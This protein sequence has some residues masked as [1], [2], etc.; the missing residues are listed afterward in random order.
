MCSS[1]IKNPINRKRKNQIKKDLSY[2]EILMKFSIIQAFYIFSIEVL[3]FSTKIIFKEKPGLSKSLSNHDLDFDKSCELKQGYLGFMDE[4]LKNNEFHIKPIFAILNM[5]YFSIFENDTAT[6]LIKTI[7]LRYIRSPEKPKEW[8]NNLCFKLLVDSNEPTPFLSKNKKK[9]EKK[10]GFLNKFKQKP[11]N[12]STEK[13]GIIEKKPGVIEEKT[14]IKHENEIIPENTDIFCV[15]DANILKSWMNSLMTFHNCLFSEKHHKA[16]KAKKI[17]KLISE[18]ESPSFFNEEGVR[19]DLDSELLKLKQDV[20]RDKLQ[21]EK[22]RNR[23]E[24][25]RKKIESKTRKLEQQ[26]RIL[27]RALQTKAIEEEK[28]AEVL[29]KQEENYKRNMILEQTRKA[30]INET[31]KEKSMLIRQEEQLLKAEKSLQDQIKNMMVQSSYDFEKLLDYGECFDVK[32]TGGN[33]T[34]L[35]DMCYKFIEPNSKPNADNTVNCLDKTKFCERCCD[36]FIGTSHESVRFRCKNKCDRVILPKFNV[37]TDNAYIMTVPQKNAIVIP[38]M[39][40]STNVTLAKTNITIAKP[41]TVINTNSG[42]LNG[43]FILNGGNKVEK[44][45][46]KTVGVK[47]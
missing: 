4:V 34:Y 21:E 43:G 46:N 30:L 10:T 18:P 13:P 33:S 14:E 25:E 17:H 20:I 7:D 32:L 16:N 37:K 40:N 26:Q 12:K 22:E 1:I 5:K 38:P 31:H 6:T 42:S 3:V 44:D 41:I 45:N 27:S 23:L 35:K 36:F 24:N 28:I 2:I 39:N 8:G 47:K 19:K 9:T 11:N 29:I 15:K